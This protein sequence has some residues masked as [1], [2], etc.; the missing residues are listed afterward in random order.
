MGKRKEKIAVLVLVIFTLSIIS[1]QPLKVEGKEYFFSILVKTADVFTGEDYLTLLKDQLA[2]IGICVN[3]EILP[4][5]YTGFGFDWDYDI[6]YARFQGYFTEPDFTGV[7]DE[8]GSLN[9]LFGYRISMDWNET[10]GTGTNEWYIKHG[11]E[12]FPPNSPERIQHYWNWEQYMM[13]NI[14]PCQPVLA[15][16]DYSMYWDTLEDYNFSKGLLQSWG[17]MYWN[18]NHIGQQS[19]NEIVISDQPWTNLNPL[20]NTDNPSR[21]ISNAIMEPLYWRDSDDSIWPHLA[22][23]ITMI[24]NTHVRIITRNGIKWQDPGGFVD[25][26]FDAKDVYFTFYM[27]MNK[28][29][30]TYV[31]EWIKDMKIIDQ[32]TLDIF[33]D[34]DPSTPENEPYSGFMSSL[35]PLI[36]PEHYLNQ[37][38]MSDGITPNT[39]HPAWKQFETNP[40]GTG[41]FQ[42]NSYIEDCETILEIFEDCWW[43]NST[44]T[45]DPKLLW[46]QRF[47][48]F[49]S[50]LSTLRIKNYLNEDEEIAHFKKGEIDIVNVD[51]SPLQYNEYIL[52]SDFEIQS[53][54][55]SFLGFF[56]YNMRSF[57]ILGNP[58]P[59][60]ED[61]SISKGLALRKAISYAMNREEMNEIVRGGLYKVIN[62]PIHPTMGIWLNP[63]IIRYDHDL[64][65]ARYYMSLAGY[66]TTTENISNNFYMGIFGI[67]V[68]LFVIEIG[69]KKRNSPLK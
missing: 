35:S 23:S 28:A 5:F 9:T 49:S 69:R 44:I 27:L 40:I 30:N 13:E 62:H 58:D 61:P 7:Y 47:G 15:P 51:L 6:Y 38:Q 12:M 32:D 60:S 3:I 21:A 25:Q 31:Y 53:K 54:V 48:D 14:L 41:L 18:G 19:I 34:G 59:C 17:K 67:T 56:A 11:R 45:N 39:S 22:E 20:N 24:N 1:T 26:Y 4:Y 8:N 66:G 46:D 33:I 10:L 63:N 43:L 64:E 68:L 65:K 50:G 42:M 2:T 37:T 55:K 29:D 52:S 57:R 36:L 16:N